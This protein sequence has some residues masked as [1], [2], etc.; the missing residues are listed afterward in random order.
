MSEG[1]SIIRVVSP[2]DLGSLLGLEGSQLPLLVVGRRDIYSTSSQLDVYVA[3][4][5]TWAWL[6]IRAV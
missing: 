1:T 2:S 4:P 5:F 6:G 3:E